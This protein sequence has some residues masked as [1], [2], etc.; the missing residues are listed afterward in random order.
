M[1][2]VTV[3]NKADH[4][5]RILRE[6]EGAVVAFSGGVDSTLLLWLARESLGDRCVAVTAVSPSLPE[7]ERR[8]AADLAR[9]LGARHL[10]IASH[11]LDRPEYAANGP[12]RCYHCK[13]ELFE[14]CV[15]TARDLGL[16]SVVYGAT[17]DDVGDYRPGMNAA[18]ERGVRAPLLEAGLGKDEIRALSRAFDLPTS[19]KP[20]LACLAS[21]IP[22][23]TPVSGERLRRI[24]AAEELLRDLGFLEVRVRFHGEVARIE[25]GASEWN[26]FSD[27]ELRRKI[28]QGVRN[29]GFRFVALD[30]EPF[31]SGRL[32]EVQDR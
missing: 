19:G 14:I 7:R 28:A 29:A 30:V 15:R 3:M 24:E 9:R 4:A 13:T 16:P 27:P 21:R 26:R 32:V 10:E 23:G 31:R 22:F 25:V 1:V 2:D 5:Q 11:E 18:R 20:A 12:A 8:D 6:L 17:R